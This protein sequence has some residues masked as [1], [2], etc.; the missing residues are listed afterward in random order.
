MKEGRSSFLK[1]RTKKLF[2][3]GASW[4]PPSEAQMNKSFF[5][6]FFSKKVV[7]PFSFPG[8]LPWRG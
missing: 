7:L 2:L 5:A 8:A 3:I 6:T 1:K 4:V